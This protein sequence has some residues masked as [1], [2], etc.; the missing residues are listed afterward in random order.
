MRT[1]D[2]SET[3]RLLTQLRRSELVPSVDSQFS[4]PHC[5]IN[6]GVT[7]YN[8]N[9]QLYNPATC[10]AIAGNNIAAAGIPINTAAPE[11]LQRLPGSK[12]CVAWT[13]TLP[14]RMSSSSRTTTPLTLVSTGTRRRKD[15]AF[16][17][18][19]YDNSA[20][21]KTPELGTLPSGFGT[22]SSYTHARSYGLGYTHTFSPT[23]VNEL[24]VGY[25]RDDYGYQPPFYGE[26]LSAGL[27]IVNANRN[28]ETSG[29]ALIGGNSGIDYT[30]DYGLYAVP[31]NTIEL[32]DTVDWEHGHHSLKF[33]AT[34]ILR[35]M[36][37]FRPISG[38]G[39]FNFGNGDFTGFPTAEML[40]GFTDSYSIGAQ[41]GYFNNIAWEDGF[42]GQDEWRVN[43]QLTL[44]LGLRYDIITRPY[45]TQNRQASFDLNTASS[46]YGQI[47][48]AGK[49]GVSR[50]IINN[51]FGDFAPRVGF[52]YDLQGNGRQVLRGGYGIFYFPDYGGIDNQLGQQ[53]PFG[54][55]L[56]YNAQNGYCVTFTG[57][58]AAPGAN[59]G[60]DQSA[61][62]ATALPAPGFPGFN[63]ATPPA[64]LST[65]AVNR[66]EKNQ[67]IQEWNLQLEQQFGKYDVMNIAYVGSRSE[68]LST[69]YN[70]NIYHFGTGLQNFP[71]DGTITY[72]NYNGDAN[73]NGLQLHY[74]HR[75]GND[76]LMTASYAW[77]HGLDD[78]PGSNLSSTSPLY[79]DPHAD[80]GQF[81]TGPAER[82]QLIHSLSPAV[83]SR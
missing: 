1:G 75:Q 34:G 44:Q 78:S 71:T 15:V 59:Y 21:T 6:A 43:K 66:N 39:Y 11:L 3:A 8:K 28:Q 57:Q 58:T 41:N 10:T 73:Y 69:Y 38:K 79:Y 83:R 23:I 5:L 62:Q 81:A 35:N 65:L 20:F 12:P 60:C 27:G 17:R 56:A 4:E 7:T 80:Y 25:N 52:A 64:G 72:N 53:V 24:L 14:G 45:E 61:K 51:S 19:S 76:L 48:L 31:Q 29:G 2:F 40:I 54:G 32:N 74:E 63:P 30:G 36:E 33:G 82:L 16:A 50:S 77:S 18:F 47:L 46:T 37:Y 22:G 70:D 49:N 68:H 13:N 26:A 67:Q 9:G 55:S 42:F